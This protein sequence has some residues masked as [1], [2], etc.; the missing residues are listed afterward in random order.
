MLV[1]AER[2]GPGRLANPVLAQYLWLYGLP[3]RVVL[4]STGNVGWT[5]GRV[6]ELCADGC[7]GMPGPVLER[8]IGTVGPALSL[9]WSK[10]RL[11]GLHRNVGRWGHPPSRARQVVVVTYSPLPSGP[12]TSRLQRRRFERMVSW[13]SP[14]SAP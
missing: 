13:W 9:K 4:R 12:W 10:L 8:A 6:A 14:P 2:F 7:A 3:P 1:L 5:L 11:L